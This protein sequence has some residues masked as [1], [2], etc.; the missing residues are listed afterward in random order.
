MFPSNFVISL[1]FNQLLFVL[2]D[3]CTVWYLFG[4][5]FLKFS[6]LIDYAMF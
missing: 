5:F 2:I 6:I 4:N 1:Y 3:Y